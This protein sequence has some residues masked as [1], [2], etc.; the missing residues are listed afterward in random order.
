MEKK[1]KVGG[2]ACGGC[3]ASVERALKALPGVIDVKV[4]HIT[5][6][7]IVVGEVDDFAVVSAIENVG[8]D[9]LGVVE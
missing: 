3:S 7:A 4:N 6:I 1:Y 8:F 9:Y 5:G 2:M